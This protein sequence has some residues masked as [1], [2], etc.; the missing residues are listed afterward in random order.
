MKLHDVQRTVK[1]AAD[2]FD[3]RKVGC[4]GNTGLA[5]DHGPFQIPGLHGVPV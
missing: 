4:F 2:Y 1:L 3:G 5:Q